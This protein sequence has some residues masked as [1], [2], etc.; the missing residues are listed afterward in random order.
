MAASN[1]CISF[2]HATQT[3][4]DETNWTNTTVGNFGGS[5][6]FKMYD[7]YI[8]G[9]NIALTMKARSFATMTETTVASGWTYQ[10]EGVVLERD[11]AFYV[12]RGGQVAL[13]SL[14]PYDDTVYKWPHSTDSY[15]ILPGTLAVKRKSAGGWSTEHAGYVPWGTSAASTYTDACDKLAY[16]TETVSSAATLSVSQNTQGGSAY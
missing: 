2:S 3:K 5:S 1:S 13:Y 12:S 7:A 15:S 6:R 8:S 10:Y 9:Y 11:S 4:V 14:A 16:A